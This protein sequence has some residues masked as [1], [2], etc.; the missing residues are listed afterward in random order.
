MGGALGTCTPRSSAGAAQVTIELDASAYGK[1]G[2]LRFVVPREK[3]VPAK[4][5]K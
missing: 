4:F 2:R 5:K 1:P 3:F